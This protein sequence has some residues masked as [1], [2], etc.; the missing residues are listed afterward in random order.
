MLPL[1]SLTVVSLEQAVAAPF[2]T[3]QLAD[4]GARVIKIERPGTGDFARYYDETVKGLSSHFV[5]INRGKESLT[6][7][8]SQPPGQE[9]LHR[10][11]QRADVFVQNLKPGAT[12]KLG[13]G[14]QTLH[15]QYPRLICCDISGFGPDGPL[16]DRKAYDLLIQAESGLLSITGTPEQPV[17]VGVSIADIAAG[18]YALTG[19]LTALFARNE[20]GQGTVVD[21]SMLEALGEWMGYPLYYSHYRG[22]APART[23][24]TH[25]TIAPYGPYPVGDGHTVYLGIQNEREWARFCHHILQRPEWVTDS[26]FRDNAAR[27]RNRDTVDALI[28]SRFSLLTRDQ[29]VHSLEQAGIAYAQL[30]TMEDLW[31]H[32]QLRARQRWSTVQTEMGPIEAL[33]PPV[34][35]QG[36]AATMG[37]VPRLGEHTDTILQEL[38]YRGA[39][40]VRLRRLGI[41]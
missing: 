23:G 17:K 37:P 13:I 10:L 21:V 27:V 15:A 19:I 34:N 6:V 20:T 14:S 5:W 36:L 9:I 8:V 35:L 16:R 18:M 32:P 33:R 39:E 41:I 22:Q 12:G 24:S 26:R 4:W 11:L 38:G 31:N 7:D 28:S 40:I 29:V 1:A 2:T 25:A 30:N 3:R